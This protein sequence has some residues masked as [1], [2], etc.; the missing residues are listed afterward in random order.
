M[1]STC[2]LIMRQL[3]GSRASTSIHNSS[4][5]GCPPS[6]PLRRASQAVYGPV[7]S[8]QTGLNM[9]FNG[10]KNCGL[11]I[12]NFCPAHRAPIW[13]IVRACESLI[14]HASIYDCPIPSLCFYTNTCVR[15][16]AYMKH[17]YLTQI[18]NLEPER[19]QKNVRNDMCKFPLRPRSVWSGP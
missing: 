2:K 7:F 12:G 15:K 13:R 6:P 17:I 14:T 18:I 9:C 4:L 10:Q 19:A 1:G 3:V 5:S 11:T 8:D 16:P